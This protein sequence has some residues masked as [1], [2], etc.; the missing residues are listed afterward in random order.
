MKRVASREWQWVAGVAGLIVAASTLPYLVGYLAQTPDLRFGHGLID[1]V[2]YYTYLAKMWQGYWGSWTYQLPFTTESHEGAYLVTF[3]LALGHLARLAGLSLPLVYQLARLGFGFVMLLIIYRFVA[4]F[5]A[6]LRTRRL[7]FLL[8]ALASGLGWLTEILAP[9]PPGGVSPIEFWLLDGY[10]YLTLMTV[11]HFCAA[12]TLLLVVYLLLL[13]QPEGPGWREGGLA[14]LASLA[15]GVIHPHILLL[16]DL[17]PLLYW[18]IEWLRTR[19]LNRRGIVAVVAMG[20]A[21]LPLLVYDLWVF[22]TQPVF[23]A[24]AAQNVTLSPSPRIY[25]LGYGLLLVLG[26]VGVATW[27]RRRRPGLAFPLVWIGLV[28]ILIYLPWNMQRRFLEGIQIPLGMLA[29]VG[30]AEGLLP[31]VVK[32]GTDRLRWLAVVLLVALS[33]MSNIYLTVTYTVAAASRIPALFWPTDLLA[34]VDWLGA[35]SEPED[36]V[37]A[38]FEVGNLIPARI[39]HRVVLGHWMETI[40]YEEKTAAVSRFFAAETPAG[41]RLDLLERYGVAYVFYGPYER[42]LGPFDPA[43]SLCLSPV[44]ARGSVR[45]YHV[46]CSGGDGG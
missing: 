38:A 43:Q 18:G 45:I 3:Y 30:V 15:L 7:A 32:K 5:I 19:Q 2:D 4:H 35:N 29:G 25:L 23:A 12:I 21:Q 40:H 36:T 24:W 13:R 33:P 41:E 11:P 27:A 46:T 10:T 22:R 17:V 6:S 31:V 20:L 34:G 39:G 37:L 44:F 28:A 14:V 1:R 26:V 9:T 42:A 16:A 8:I